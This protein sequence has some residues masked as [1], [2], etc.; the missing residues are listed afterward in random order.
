MINESL[1]LELEQK[2]NKEF[3]HTMLLI[4]VSDEKEAKK[5]Q[6]EFRQALVAKSDRS[7]HYFVGYKGGGS[8]S[9]VYWFDEFGFWVSFNLLENRYWNAFGVTQPDG[10]SNLSIACELNFPLKGINPQIAGAFGKME[11]GGIYI[12]HRGT[13]GGGRIGIGRELFMQEYKGR[14]VDL[15]DIEQVSRVALISELNRPDLFINVG[16][17]IKQVHE[18]KERNVSNYRA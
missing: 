7:G 12:V 4:N 13:I 8:K 3:K 2:V 17:F 5:Y 6:N 1:I 9:K 15:D 11:D 10:K 16:N 14:W 18:I